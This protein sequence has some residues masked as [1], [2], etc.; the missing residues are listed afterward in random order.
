MKKI[1]LAILI[2]ITLTGCGNKL[3]CTKTIKND[4]MSQKITYKVHKNKNEINKFLEDY[5]DRY[6][7]LYLKSKDFLKQLR[8]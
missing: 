5:Y 3:K 2:G 6:T 4:V 8:N 1:I 7:G